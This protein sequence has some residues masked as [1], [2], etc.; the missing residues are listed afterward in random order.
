MKRK[1]A[2]IRNEAG[3]FDTASSAFYVGCVVS[4]LEFIHERGIAYRD[5]KPEVRRVSHRPGHMC[6][7]TNRI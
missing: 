5:L 7:H 6:L 1:T 2:A 4:A 3:G